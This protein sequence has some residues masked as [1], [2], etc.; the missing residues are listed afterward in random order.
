VIQ[1]GKDLIYGELFNRDSAGIV[2]LARH[3]S[4]QQLKA[5]AVTVQRMGAHGPLPGKVLGKEA[6]KRA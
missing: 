3:E 5:V 1:E 4:Q 6:V 2:L